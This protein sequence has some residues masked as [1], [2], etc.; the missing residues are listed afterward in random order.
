MANENA[1]YQFIESAWGDIVNRSEPYFDDISMGYQRA[2]YATMRRD[3][4]DGRFLPVYDNEVDLAVIR[5][6]CRLMHERVP[7]AKAK[8]NRLTDYTISRGFDWTVSHQ[9][10]AIGRALSAYV[11]RVLEDNQWLVLGER[12]SFEAECID[13][14]WL[15]EIALLDGDVVIN[16]MTSD[17]L[18]EPV[19]PREL[20]EWQ[21][22]EF[23]ASWTFG[24]LSRK[25][26]P[27]KPLG[28]HIVRDDAGVDWDFVPARRFL[29]WRRNVPSYAKRGVGNNYTAHVYMG[30]AD[31]VLANTAEGAAVQAAIAY[32]VEHV[33]GTTSTQAQEIIKGLMNVQTNRGALPGKP[34]SQPGKKIIPGQRVDIPAGMKYHAG[35]FGSNNASIYIDV[36]EALLRLSGTIEAFP[37]HMLT[38]DAGNNNYASSLVAESPFV[39]GRLSDQE[40]RKMRLIEFIEKL[41]RIAID[42]GALRGYSWAEVKPG[43]KVTVQPPQIISRDPAALTD[44]IAKQRE[45]RLV[46]KRTASQQLGLDF[47]QEQ[48]NL[49]K[50]EALEPQPPAMPGMPGPG[51]PPQPGQPQPP[52]LPAPAPE[53]GK[54]AQEPVGE[55]LKESS[56]DE[57]KHPRGPDGKFISAGV[58]MSGWNMDNDAAKW[59]AKK[60]SKLE[61]L[62][63]AGM[64][65][66]LEAAYESAAK[67]PNQ[68]IKGV[69][70]AKANLLSLK[71]KQAL[72]VEPPKAG[73][74]K[75][76][77][78]LGTQPGG[79]YQGPDGKKYYVKTPDDP[80]LVKN[81]Y[82]AFK[83]YQLAGAGTVTPTLAAVD[84]KM[85]IATE[86]MESTKVDWSS[87]QAKAAASKDFAAHA[88][89]ANW[90]A[91]GAGSENPMDNIRIDAATGK[92]ALVDAGG[93]LNRKGTG[94]IK[95][96]GDTVPEWDTLRDAS[97]NPS[98]AAAFGS[99]TPAQLIESGKK[100]KSISDEA[101]GSLVDQ[102]G[103]QD[104]AAQQQ[105]KSTLIARRDAIL[106]KVAAL[107]AQMVPKPDP[108]PAPVQATVTPD[109]V[110]SN[111]PEPTPV[112][113][114]APMAVPKPPVIMSQS[115]SNQG[116]QKHLDAIHKLA[117]D[118]DVAAI[119]AYATNATSTQTYAKK[120]HT[121]KQEVLLALGSKP[122]A[123]PV[124]PPA[125][126]P[127]VPA[128]AIPA[129]PQFGLQS[130]T[131]WAAKAE[132]LAKQGDLAALT[133]FKPPKASMKPTMYHHALV[134]ALGGKSPYEKLDP[135]TKFGPEPIKPFMGI[136]TDVVE[137][138][139]QAE[140]H[141]KNGSLAGVMSLN[142]PNDQAKAYQAEL[143]YHLGGPV[144]V[145]KVKAKY[146]NAPTVPQEAVGPPK[147]EMPLPPSFVSSNKDYVA[148]N[149]WFSTQAHA[150]AA[151]GNLAMLKAMSPPA[152]PKAQ[153]YHKQLINELQNQLYPPAPDPVKTKLLD[154][155]A[156]LGKKLSA[157]PMPAAKKV[158]YWA[159]VGSAAG[160]N[161]QPVPA[162]YVPQGSAALWDGGHS[163]WKTKLNSDEREA[164]Q[165]YT[166]GS[167]DSINALLRF[168]DG[169]EN[170]RLLAMAAVDGVKK[171]AVPLPV[172]LKLSRKHD[173]DMSDLQP[174]DVVSEKGLLSTATSPEVWTGSNQWHMVVAPGVKG[175]PAKTFSHHPNE[176]EVILPP[177]VR[178]AVVKKT[179]KT[180]GG[181]Y[182]IEAVI[183]PD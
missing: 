160:I 41:C 137:F 111:T 9:N 5:A 54:G 68:Y 59:A 13:G 130:L 167:Y 152:S 177:N 147:F 158:G 77:G 169:D 25:Y 135:M 69:L 15:A 80:E 65:S 17:A 23:D 34:P 31:K 56:W 28:Y 94:G 141:L 55:S 86:W 172:G 161:E 33:E 87:A 149:N 180:Y 124:Q 106:A 171:A 93:S 95:P 143:A 99:M 30:R 44:A 16:T 127:A 88:W 122:I 115:K 159:V 110:P 183:L 178:I 24:V 39:Q 75:Q 120:L 36:M 102:V 79:V 35:L 58:D 63:A 71:T 81:E 85:A 98:A 43:L 10:R 154:D 108:A 136:Q 12:E 21:A 66:E 182:D 70:K 123:A 51:M 153:A 104:V 60:I 18:V 3:R 121:Y 157:N 82:L 134:T 175:L 132:T 1:I 168:N 129:P 90:D 179:P 61:H 92:Y 109:A 22:I 101:I 45:L 53:Q 145:D 6:M 166:G 48:M 116:Y 64:W 148:Q 84:G 103:P 165:A 162:E 156:A 19:N 163:S 62:A 50:E 100:L 14:E 83:L 76:G 97:I 170:D 139:K 49:K 138:G 181:G 29:H 46:S 73:W 107:E 128:Q 126:T 140:K 146:A 67:K 57:S 7:M 96:F 74:V 131:D 173:G 105:L 2:Q 151:S 150:V 144:A 47:E 114:A 113:A 91:V 174:G 20:E 117:M 142:A 32:I 118:G 40:V 72:K 52:G 176:V 37:E 112:V 89:L 133:S 78:S 27:Q 125:A 26:R 4:L 164:V 42:A 119:Q 8:V 38:G 11:K 155:Y